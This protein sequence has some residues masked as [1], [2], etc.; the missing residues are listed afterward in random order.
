MNQPPPPRDWIFTFG[1]GQPHA[2][3]FVRIFGTMDTAR[4]EMVRRFSTKWS[5]MYGSEDAAGVS[6]YNL[7]ELKL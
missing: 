5:M 7:K 2:G 1:M 4:E 3:H 6:K